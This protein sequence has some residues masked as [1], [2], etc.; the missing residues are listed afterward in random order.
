MTSMLTH[1]WF[2]GLFADP[3]VADILSPAS[4]LMRF[5]KIEAAWTM[6][7]SDVGAA[8]RKICEKAVDYIMS[9][10]IEDDMLRAGVVQDGLPIPAFVRTLKATA[11][12]PFKEVL[13]VGLTSQDVMDTALTL[14]LAPIFE[15][16]RERLVALNDALQFLAGQNG[17]RYLMGY[18]RMQAA[19][20]VTADARILTWQRPLSDYISTLDQMAVKLAVLQWGGPVGL[21]DHEKAAEL[22]AA[23]AARLGVRDL[24]HAWHTTRADIAELGSFIARLTGSLAKMGQDTAMMAQRGPEDITLKSGGS[25]SAMP[26]KQNPILSEM[27]VTLA[28]YSAQQATLLNVAMVHE[29]ERSGTAWVLEF[30]ALPDLLQVCGCALNT[31]H[32]LT[33]QIVTVGSQAVRSS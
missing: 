3:E 32:S 13:H 21:R 11:P 26:H 17:G 7:L 24:G 6:A 23:F 10:V 2:G 4:E 28:Q 22:G 20:P 1:A 5:R 15:L 25:S 33:K 12:E 8:D 18:T 14:S 31:A 29:Q 9:V 16:F 19:L 30:M 27:L